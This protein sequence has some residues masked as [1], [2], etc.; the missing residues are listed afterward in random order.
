M[1]NIDFS[2]ELGMRSEEWWQRAAS[3]CSYPLSYTL[4]FKPIYMARRNKTV[5]LTYIQKK[6]VDIQ[7][8]PAFF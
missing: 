8:S 2:E 1:G 6:T 7:K 3:N 5:F 4:Y